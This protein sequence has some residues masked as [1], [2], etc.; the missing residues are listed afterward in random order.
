MS[1]EQ[2]TFWIPKVDRFEIL[3]CYA[4]TEIGHGSNVRGIETT[5]DYDVSSEHFVLHSPTVSSMK[6][7]VGALG[8]WA[9]HAIVL[10]RLRIHGKEYG[11]HLFLVQI[12]DLSTQLSLPGIEIYEIGAKAIGTLGGV[13][14]GALRFNKVRVPRQHMF[15]GAAIVQADGAYQRLTTSNAHSLRSMVIIRGM[16][17]EEIG[18]GIAKALYIASKYLMFRRQFQPESQLGSMLEKCV[19]EYSGVRYR[20]IPAICRVSLPR[21]PV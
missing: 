9:T 16:M 18:F 20:L 4:Q 15:Q 3:G 11:N 19:I 8:C 1:Q 7:W 10:A 21:Y 5:A 6:F 12:R 13:D 17:I 2:K 14:N